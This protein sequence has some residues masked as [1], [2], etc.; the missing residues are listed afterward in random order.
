MA[1]APEDKGRDWENDELPS[2]GEGQIRDHLRNLES[3]KSMGPDEIHL[4]VLKEVADGVAK[5]LSIIFEKSW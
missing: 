4:Q 1:W 5:P 2:V 3:H